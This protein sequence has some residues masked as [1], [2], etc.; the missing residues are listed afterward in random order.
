[1]PRMRRHFEKETVRATYATPP[2]PEEGLQLL[3]GNVR[4]Q[5]ELGQASFQLP[6]VPNPGDALGSQ[7]WISDFDLEQTPFTQ[8]RI[9]TRLTYIPGSRVL[10]RGLTTG[11]VMLFPDLAKLLL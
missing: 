11:K 3:N 7:V 2:A 9:Y 6:A 8:I 10:H 4:R 5:L 1:M